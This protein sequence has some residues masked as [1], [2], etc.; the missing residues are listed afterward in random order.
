MKSY[1]RLNCRLCESNNL[2]IVLKLTP[3]PPAD[4]FIPKDQLSIKQDLIPLELYL[5]EDCKHTQIGHVIDAEEVY[6]NYI[7]ETA[8]TL[9]LG[10]HFKECAKSVVEKYE[11]KNGGLVIDIGSNDGILLK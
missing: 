5:C 7:Y 6:L 1:K 9:G 8:S 3:T 10:E 2:N 4:S 11:P